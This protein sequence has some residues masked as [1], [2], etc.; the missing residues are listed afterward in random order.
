MRAPTESPRLGVLGGMGPLATVDFMHKLIKA[1][2]T[3]SDQDHL[4]VVA[5]SVPQIPD[6]S[7]AFMMGSDAP[8]PYLLDGLRTLET[9]GAKAIAIPCNT[10]HVWH[11]RLAAQT[12]TTILHIGQ[13]AC[14][15]VVRIAGG[16]CRVGL[17]AT[18]ATLAARIY[19]DALEA[20]GATVVEPDQATQLQCVMEGIRAVKAG[21]LAGGRTL[22]LDA[23]HALAES[24]GGP[25]AASVHRNPDR[26]GGCHIQSAQRR[27]HRHAGEGLRGVVETIFLG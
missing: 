24:E 14:A 19:H 4:P 1:T 3:Q 18:S 9:A 25:V 27:H 11:G 21:R 12:H 22:L 23:A 15:Q 20:A 10:A 26:A 5:Y 2:P 13:I 7:T 6:R 17:M 16:S 8:W